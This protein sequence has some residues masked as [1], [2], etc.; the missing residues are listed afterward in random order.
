M[1][2]VR[3]A[4]MSGAMGSPTIGPMRWSW[5]RDWTAMWRATTGPW[6]WC[7]CPPRRRNKMTV[8]D[9]TIVGGRSLERLTR[10]AGRDVRLPDGH[11]VGKTF[12]RKALLECQWQHSPARSAA[13]ASNHLPA[14]SQNRP[15]SIDFIGPLMRQ[16]YYLQDGARET[17]P[18]PLATP[19]PSFQFVQ[20]PPSSIHS[21]AARKVNKI[22]ETS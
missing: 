16:S 9:N 19:F 20:L 2:C 17:G 22:K 15:Q 21:H 7:G 14:P 12:P 6:R 13:C 10:I 18:R 11:T 8:T 3:P 1:W 5:R 4:W